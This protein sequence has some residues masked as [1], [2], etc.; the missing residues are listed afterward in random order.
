[1]S[2]NKCNLKIF[3]LILQVIIH[4]LNEKVK[5]I[6]IIVNETGNV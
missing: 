2:K 6:L 4:L 3:K 1:M 5:I